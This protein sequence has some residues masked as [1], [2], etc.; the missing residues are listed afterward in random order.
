[1]HRILH[2]LLENSKKKF[3]EKFH[4]STHPTTSVANRLALL[5]QFALAVVH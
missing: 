1:M 4:P 5:G 2:F 3:S